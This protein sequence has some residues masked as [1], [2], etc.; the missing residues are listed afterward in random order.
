MT[1]GDEVPGVSI[2]TDHF[3]AE[4]RRA[5]CEVWIEGRSYEAEIT[6]WEIAY[7]EGDAEVAVKGD[8]F[9]TGGVKWDGCSN[10]SFKTDACMFHACD[11]KYLEAIGEILGKCWDATATVIPETW[12]P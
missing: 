10:W 6:I 7:W 9:A 1:T 4:L 8:V 12:S 2:E 5:T 3:I 11:R